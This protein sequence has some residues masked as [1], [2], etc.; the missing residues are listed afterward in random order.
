MMRLSALLTGFFSL[1]MPAGGEAA[2]LGTIGPVY[3]VQEEDL[4]QVMMQ[5]ARHSEANGSW[6]Q[7][8][9]SH[10]DQ[11]AD[12]S[13]VANGS[14]PRAQESRTY[15]LDPS[16]TLQQP[17]LRADGSVLYPTGTRINPLD[18]VNYRKT[19]CFF[20]AGD[21]EQLE[22]VRMHCGMSAR[23]KRIAVAGDVRL[24]EPEL[25]R[26]YLDQEG[27][28]VARFR[29]TELPARVMAREKLLQVEVIGL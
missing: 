13:L 1:L 22:W 24:L 28:L 6:Q 10:R 16:V 15:T 3:E 27:H 4:V 12:S 19:L 21:R 11:M 9:E 2:D 17:L 7:R 26:V 18:Y 14:L 5:Q 25:G 29:L 8:M 23:D 20:D